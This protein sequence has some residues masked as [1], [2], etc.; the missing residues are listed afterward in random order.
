MIK[1]KRSPVT[2][3]IILRIIKT[4]IYNFRLFLQLLR[5]QLS[6]FL[7]SVIYSCKLK[8]AIINSN[9]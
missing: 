2:Q 4:I 3:R 5:D 9:L 7:T 6:S 8:P 1:I